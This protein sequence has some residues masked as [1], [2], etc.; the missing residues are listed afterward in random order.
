MSTVVIPGMSLCPSLTDT[1]TLT[2]MKRSWLS[3]RSAELYL[4]HPRRLAR[5][6]NLNHTIIVYNHHTSTHPGN[7][8]DPHGQRCPNPLP[9]IKWDMQKTARNLSSSVMARPRLWSLPVPRYHPRRASWPIERDH[10]HQSRMPSSR[11]HLA[12]LLLSHHSRIRFHSS[13][14]RRRPL[15]RF[16]A[17]PKARPLPWPRPPITNNGTASSR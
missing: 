17:M 15:H 4:A 14:P 2:T 11:V 12:H 1:Q 5:R 9:A 7:M 3:P 10:S 13:N 8:P 16:S 6:L